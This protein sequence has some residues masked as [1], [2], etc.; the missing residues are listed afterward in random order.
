MARGQSYKIRHCGICGK[1]IETWEELVKVK[2]SGKGRKT[3]TYHE[4]CIEQERQTN[5]RIP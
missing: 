5:R 1:Q 4:Y 3:N 2:P